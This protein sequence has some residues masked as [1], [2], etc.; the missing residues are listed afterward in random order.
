MHC[1][2]DEL[3]FGSGNVVRS[4]TVFER[5]KPYIQSSPQ[6]LTHT[7][8]AKKDIFFLCLM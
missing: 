8:K 7:R 2:I 1:N 6:K 3:L 5:L 4:V